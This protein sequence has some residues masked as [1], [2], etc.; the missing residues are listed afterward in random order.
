MSNPLPYP[1][2]ILIGEVP[3]EPELIDSTRHSFKEAIQYIN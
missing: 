3:I 1:P 2:T